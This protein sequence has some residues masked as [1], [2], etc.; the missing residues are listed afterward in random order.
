LILEPSSNKE[1][2]AVN[3]ADI[4]KEGK[5]CHGGIQHNQGARKKEE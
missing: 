1:T 5:R 2:E 4:R 3:R